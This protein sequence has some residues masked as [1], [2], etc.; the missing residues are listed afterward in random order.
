MR[1]AA[2]YISCLV[3]RRSKGK[4]DDVL[5]L[6]QALEAGPGQHKLLRVKELDDDDDDDDEHITLHT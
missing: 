2:T 4:K 3:F 6:L 1:I 5:M